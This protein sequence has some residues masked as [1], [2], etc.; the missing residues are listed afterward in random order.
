MNHLFADEKTGLAKIKLNTWED[1]VIEEE[2]TRLDFVC[3]IRNPSRASWSL[4][5][6]YEINNEIKP[7][8]PDFLIIRKDDKSQ[9]GYV[10]DILE[11]HNPDF[12]DNL[13]KAK[14]F[15]R[16]A[17]AEPKVG[18]IQLIRKIKDGGKEKFK[19]LDFS[20]FGNEKSF[21]SKCPIHCYKK[22]M[23]A[24]IKDVMKFSGP[25]LIIYSPMQFIKHI[26]E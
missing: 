26:F 17:E 6:P 12:K 8:F 21:C 9:A 24:K 16:Y 15:A 7:A 11:P 22:D 20:K 2:Q 14:G 18:R 25:R 4:T 13:P 19:R 3:W 1:G 10:I 23:K 5:I